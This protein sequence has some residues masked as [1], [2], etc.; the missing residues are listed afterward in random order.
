MTKKEKIIKLCCQVNGGHHR[1]RMCNN[2]VCSDC[3]TCSDKC[4]LKLEKRV[5]GRK[6]YGY[7]EAYHRTIRGITDAGILNIIYGILDDHFCFKSK[8]KSQYAAESLEQY[9]KDNKLE[10]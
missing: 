7:W 5:R 3:I 6:S 1:C 8:T 9:I 10:K 2:L 4:N